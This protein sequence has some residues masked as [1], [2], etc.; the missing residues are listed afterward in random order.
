MIYTRFG[1][2]VCLTSA[3]VFPVWIERL[4]GEIRWHFKGPERSKGKVEV[5]PI[6]FA[7]ALSIDERDGHTPKGEPILDHKAIH[8]ALFKADG[9]AGEIE[10][11]CQDLAP[12][13]MQKLTRWAESDELEVTDLFAKADPDMVIY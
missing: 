13:Q 7:T 12:D 5:L 9:G 10:R 11:R 4:A 8:T 3:V 2:Q 1:T 6:W